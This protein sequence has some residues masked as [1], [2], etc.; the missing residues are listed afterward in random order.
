MLQIAGG[1]CV[2]CSPGQLLSLCL[3]GDGIE[4]F[5]LGKLFISVWGVF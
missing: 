2:G 1:T 3:P 5:S 4:L